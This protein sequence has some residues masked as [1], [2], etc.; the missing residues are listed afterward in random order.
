MSRS[1]QNRLFRSAIA[2]TGM[3]FAAPETCGPLPLARP[4]LEQGMEH[5][6]NRWT[7][8]AFCYLLQ[9]KR[10]NLYAVNLPLQ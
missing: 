9:T 6:W 1:S 2:A 3:N 4:R 10:C 7:P 8:I 5:V